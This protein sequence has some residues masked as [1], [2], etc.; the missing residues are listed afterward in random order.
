MFVVDFVP[1][2]V[3]ETAFSLVVLVVPFSASVDELVPLSLVVSLVVPCPATVVV[4][5]VSVVSVPVL[6]VV[7][8]PLDVSSV[9][10][11]AVVFPVLPVSS[12]ACVPGYCQL[13]LGTSPAVAFWYVM[14]C[15][16]CFATD[17][18]PVV[19]S[20]SVSLSVSLDDVWLSVALVD[21]LGV[22]TVSP[23]STVVSVFVDNPDEVVVFPFVPLCVSLRSFV[24]SDSPVPVSF[25]VS[26]CVSVVPASDSCVLV[27]AVMLSFSA[28]STK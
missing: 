19:V 24:V 8:V 3:L 10:L 12:C 2:A 14:D 18:L 28:S 22:L 6:L 25:D 21:K 4:S 23:S 16:F 20:V 1:V 9:E 5:S 13:R 17:L 7:E 26:L 11:V 27:A 15:G